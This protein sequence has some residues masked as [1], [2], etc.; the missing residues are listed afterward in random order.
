M[1]SRNPLGPD[2]AIGTDVAT[3]QYYLMYEAYEQRPDR[4]TLRVQKGADDISS[5]I[6]RTEDYTVA[7]RREAQEWAT[8]EL[9]GVLAA[10]PTAAEPSLHLFVSWWT[11]PAMADTFQAVVGWAPGPQVPTDDPE[12]NS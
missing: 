11:V 10:P 12:G 6:A 7:Q 5:P 1:G 9:A 2:D 4:W 8:H 3:E